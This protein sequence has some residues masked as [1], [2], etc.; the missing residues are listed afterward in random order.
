VPQYD[1]FVNPVTSARRAYPLVLCLQSDLV[2]GGTEAVVAPLAPRRSLTGAAGGLTPIVQ[3]DQLEYVVLTNSFTSLP[4]RDL[5]RRIANLAGDRLKL[6]AAVDL[7]YF[8][9]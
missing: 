1:V 2:A 4:A 9:V 7:L 8:G 3:I 5:D 6:M